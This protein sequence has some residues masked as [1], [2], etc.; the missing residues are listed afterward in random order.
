MYYDRR[1]KQRS[2]ATGNN[3][4]LY[5]PARKL[6]L[7]PKFHKSRVGHYRVRSKI[8][9]HDYEILGKSDKKQ[10]VHINRLSPAHDYHATD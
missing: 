5:N 10:G 1:G 3:V 6:G 8:S 4:Y 2:F 9:E 7:S